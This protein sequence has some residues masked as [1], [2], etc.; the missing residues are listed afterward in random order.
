MAAGQSEALAEAT[1]LKLAFLNLST[2]A[3]GNDGA[4]A[5]AQAPW[6]NSLSWLNLSWN[7][8]TASGIAAIAGSRRLTGLR[9]LDV[10]DNAPG[11]GGLRAIAA[12]PALRGLTTLLVRGSS[13]RLAGLTSAVVYEFLATL[14][15]PNLRRLD[16]SHLPLGTMGT[17][18][19]AAAKFGNLTRLHVAHCKLNDAAMG[20]L[21]T[22]PSLQ[23]LLEFDASQN[24][25]RS[26]V[27]LL[28][29]RRV[30]PRL[31]A[32]NFSDSRIPS[33][34]VRKLKRRPGVVCVTSLESAP[35]PTR[36]ACLVLLFA[37][38][39][40]RAADV[41]PVDPAGLRGP[42]VLGGGR[43]NDGGDQGVR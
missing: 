35:M 2:C 43:D 9:Y 40:T 24:E 14:N 29:D 32:A 18:A 39:A 41:P 5:L 15:M 6:L 11:I 28:T 10:S 38:S 37:L 3:I 34:L 30:M 23:N 19:L 16:L 25:L 36:L 42:L 26:G 17:R 7:R 22:T 31:A 27:A 12:N 21:L 13:D 8:L 33:D 20:P 4:R 1:S